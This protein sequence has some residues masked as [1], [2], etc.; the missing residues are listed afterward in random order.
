M[1][2]VTADKS[3]IEGVEFTGSKVMKRIA[4]LDFQRVW[5]YL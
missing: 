2:T 3:T 4:T 1:S 5:P